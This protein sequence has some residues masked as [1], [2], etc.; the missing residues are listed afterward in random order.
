MINWALDTNTRVTSLDTGHVAEVYNLIATN[1][2]HLD[3]WLR[4][5]SGI[6]TQ[7]DAHQF[8]AQFKAKLQQG[9]G[10]LCGIWHRDRLAGA[11]VCWY[12][13]P[14]NRNAEIGYWLGE[15]FT[16]QGLATRATK[17]VLDYLFSETGLHRIEM[18]CG[19]G[20]TKSRAIPERLG[21][22]LEGVRRASHWI[23][24]RFVDHAV[25]G[26]LATEWPQREAQS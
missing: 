20:N 6:E 15:S 18:Q 22:T 7:A 9:N 1:R 21:F 14:E 16:G 17:R 10:F 13:H 24:N 2:A 25:Y 4:W 5:S 23:T 26:I 12:I 19:V 11:V 8:V 3:R